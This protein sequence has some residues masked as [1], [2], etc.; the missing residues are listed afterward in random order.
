MFVNVSPVTADCG[1]SDSKAPRRCRKHSGCSPAEAYFTEYVESPVV[2]TSV[3]SFPVIS[4]ETRSNPTLS[5]A[6]RASDPPDI[7]GDAP[8]PLAYL[9]KPVRPMSCPFRPT[10]LVRSSL[11]PM[12]DAV[13]SVITCVPTSPQCLMSVY[14]P[15]DPMFSYFLYSGFLRS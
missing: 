12:A 10:P 7:T 11:F 4:D 2:R 15:S 1:Q 3:Q 5:R 8:D 13:G 14:I 6:L 9:R